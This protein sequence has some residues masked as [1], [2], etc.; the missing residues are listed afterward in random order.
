[1][2]L[3]DESRWKG[4][5]FDGAWR[6]ADG[7]T[8][9]VVEP[10]TGDQLGTV[11]L[12]A[13]SDVERSAL[14][15][16][17]AQ[18]AWASAP[19][20]ERAAVMRRAAELWEKHSDEVQLWLIRESGGTRAKTRKELSDAMAECLEAAALPSHAIGEVLPS[21]IAPLS[22]SRRVPIGVVGVIAPFNAPVKL[23]IRSVAPALGLGNAVIL[24]PDPRTP[25]SG[26]V[27]FAE[28]F[29]EAGLPPGVLHVLPGGAAVGSAMVADPNVNAVSFTGS[30][31]AGQ[32]VAELG[33]K[34][35]TRVHLEL[36]GKNSVIVMSDADLD[37]A[38]TVTARG[39]FF[40]AGQGCMVIGRHLV[41]ESIYDEYVEKLVARAKGLT[42]GNPATD[43]VDLGPIIDERQRDRIHSMV[44][45]TVDKGATLLTGG[46]YDG[47]F[48]R[49]TVVTGAGPGTPVYDD[50][51]FGPVASVTPFATADEAVALA[52][53]T[54]YGLD[55]SIMTADIGAGLQIALRIPTGTAHINDQTVEDDA[56][57][58]F[59]GMR[60]SGNS[61][62]FGGAEANIEAYTDTRWITM[63]STVP[64]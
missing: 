10:A 24:K 5:V 63:R 59:G 20:R 30:T 18:V 41:H 55:L 51:V 42:V 58:P 17:L 35:F 47:L 57:A 23:A 44:T 45:S 25:V 4:K 12:A 40:N 26:G 9:S 19:A 53:D 48:Y 2:T 27:V 16:S 39:S 56:N 14:K 32:S 7:G 43:D 54:D 6:T 62:R 38:V 1:M 34:H 11:G 64:D 46:T 52:S 28:I 3:L 21:E 13:I 37:R 36:G 61:A 50:E 8:T 15:A 60:H 31:K 33:A 49:P 29:E 22:M